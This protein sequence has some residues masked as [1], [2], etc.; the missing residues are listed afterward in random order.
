[1]KQILEQI[2]AKISQGVDENSLESLRA[3]FNDV[4]NIIYIDNSAQKLY[5]PNNKEELIDLIEDEDIN[6]SDI[7]TSLITD[8]SEIFAYSDRIDFSGINNW[9]TSNVTDMSYMFYKC[10]N[11]N[12]ELSFDTS[13]VVNMRYMFSGCI[14]FNKEI[15][16]DTSKA[17]LHGLLFGCTSYKQKLKFRTKEII[18]NKYQPKNKEELEKLLGYRSDIGVFKNTGFNN[19][20][21]SSLNNIFGSSLFGNSSN[22]DLAEIDTSL[23]T[24]MDSLFYDKNRDDFDRVA[25]WDTYNV[26]NMRDM[27]KYCDYFDVELHFNTK[28]VVNMSGMFYACK[29]FNQPVNFNTQNVTD[30][31]CIFQ[32]CERFNQPINFNTSKVSNMG[33]MFAQCENFNQPLNFDTRKVTMFGWMFCECKRLNQI[34]DFYILNGADTTKMFYKSNA[35]LK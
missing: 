28:N 8:M 14:N 20:Y 35:R 17:I 13:N 4:K 30:M 7:D 15:N 21:S 22:V 25:N 32:A 1:M 16:F 6:L 24:D 31:G 2:K 27:F 10:E 12:E 18:F 5:K 9:N 3:F 29:N 33:E 26:T 23:V 34:F 11:F 19:L